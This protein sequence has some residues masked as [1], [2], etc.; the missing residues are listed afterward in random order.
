[1]SVRT[2][3]DEYNQPI[4]DINS[5]YIGEFKYFGFSDVPPHCLACDGS[6]VSRETYSELFEVFGETFG[7]GDGETTFNLPDFRGAFLRCIGG[8]AAALGVE[9]AQG[10]AL[11]GLRFALA[12]VI[13]KN[14][15]SPAHDSSGT[16]MPNVNG[17]GNKLF[18]GANGNGSLF[19]I[20]FDDDGNPAPSGIWP[21]PEGY[22]VNW[23]DETSVRQDPETRPMNYAVNVCVVYE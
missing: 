7:A 4:S 3:V 12:N 21:V 17:G 18:F 5:G 16:A 14:T 2:G 13:E 10:T 11:N 1:M 23:N 9:Q 8:N 19:S 20:A 15:L 22:N 6:E